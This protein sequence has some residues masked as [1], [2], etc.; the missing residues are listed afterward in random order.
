MLLFHVE[1]SKKALIQSLSHEVYGKA[2]AGNS[3]W[4]QPACETAQG[5]KPVRALQGMPTP[6]VA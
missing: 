2:A 1:Q 5:R 6:L 3:G 4:T